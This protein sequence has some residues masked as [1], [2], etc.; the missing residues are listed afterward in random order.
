MSSTVRSFMS[1]NWL[2]DSCVANAP[3]P[4]VTMPL[5]RS[6]VWNQPSAW[7]RSST[8]V[9]FTRDETL[10]SRARSAPTEPAAERQ[11]G[12]H[13]RAR[14][15]PRKG[16]THG[17]HGDVHARGRYCDLSGYAWADVAHGP[18]CGDAVPQWP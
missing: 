12:A 18:G 9:G 3:R 5:P 4:G 1:G 15:I 11:P 14:R 2:G 8:W 6:M 16:A 17:C 7:T 13:Y 10:A